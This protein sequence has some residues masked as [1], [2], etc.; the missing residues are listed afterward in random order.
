MLKVSLITATILFSCLS[1]TAQTSEKTEKVDKSMP[2]ISMLPKKGEHK[3]IIQLNHT[4][5]FEYF[6]NKGNFLGKGEGEWL[7]VTEV[8]SPTIFVKQNGKTER[9]TVKKEN[10]TTEK[11]LK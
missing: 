11:K 10:A 3:Q 1:A 6:D 4:G 5:A 2:P 8:E 7:D 9:Y